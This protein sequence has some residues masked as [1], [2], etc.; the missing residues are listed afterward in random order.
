MK[1]RDGQEEGRGQRRDVVG[2]S[3]R[4]G[5]QHEN[6]ERASRR[7][8]SAP[9]EVLLVHREN[10]IEGRRRWTRDAIEKHPANR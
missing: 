10:R 3:A 6:R 7:D 1:R 8:D 2:D 4:E 5:E 9:D